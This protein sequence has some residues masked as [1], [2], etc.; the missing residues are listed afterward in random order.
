MTRS[1][2]PTAWDER[3]MLV[4]FLA[5]TRDTV[6]DKCEGLAD[7]H[8][9]AAPLSTSP[10]MTIGAIVSHL[11][12]VEH[13]WIETLFAG[14]PDLGPW[15]DEEPDKEMSIGTETPLPRLLEEYADQARRDDAIIASH[16]LDDRSVEPLRNGEQVTL[17]WIILHLIEENARH[18]GHLDIL[19]ELADGVT[20]T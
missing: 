4:T 3:S 9:G 2:L 18:N 12:W 14:G 20:G 19:R 7:E 5:Y 17:R 8:V 15:T 16:D 11:R 13:N 6:R 1:D 10:L